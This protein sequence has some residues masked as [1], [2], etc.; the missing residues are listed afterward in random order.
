MCQH[1]RGRHGRSSEPGDRQTGVGLRVPRNGSSV[2][3]RLGAVTVDDSCRRPHRCRGPDFDEHPRVNERVREG[4]AGEGERRRGNGGTERQTKTTVHEDPC[5]IGQPRRSVGGMPD[6]HH[7]FP[8]ARGLLSGSSVGDRWF[9]AFGLEEAWSP[10]SVQPGSSDGCSGTHRAQPCRVQDRFHSSAW[11]QGGLEATHRWK[12]ALLSRPL[13]A[14]VQVTHPGYNFA[15][16][17][18]CLCVGDYESGE[19]VSMKA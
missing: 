5:Q 12:S 4:E 11:P 16:L 14:S 8:A 10:E 9:E 19:Y 7:W 17:C 3:S 2:L 15:K 18:M 13:A 1:V 6:E